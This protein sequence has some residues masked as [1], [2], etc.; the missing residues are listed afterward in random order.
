MKW[1]FKTIITTVC[2][3]FVG[4]TDEAC[5]AKELPVDD[6]RDTPSVLQVPRPNAIVTSASPSQV[7]AAIEKFWNTKEY[8]EPQKAKNLEDLTRKALSWQYR[9]GRKSQ[10][11]GT[12]TIGTNTFI[13]DQTF[14]LPGS[15]DFIQQLSRDIEGR[16]VA[17]ISETHSGYYGLIVCDKG[18]IIRHFMDEEGKISVNVGR[19]PD[20]NPTL[21]DDGVEDAWQKLV[22]ASKV[23]NLKLHIFSN[24]K[25]S[26]SKEL[27]HWESNSANLDALVKAGDGLA[28]SSNYEKA[29]ASY[30][31]A[32]ITAQGSMFERRGDLKSFELVSELVNKLEECEMQLAI[33]ASSDGAGLLQTPN[34]SALAMECSIADARKAVANSTHTSESVSSQKVSNLDEMA[35]ALSKYEKECRDTPSHS[36][37]FARAGSKTIIFDPQALLPSNGKLIRSLSS[38]SSG[39]VIAGMLKSRVCLLI[40][41]DQGQVTRCFVSVDGKVIANV[42]KLPEESPKFTADPAA[43]VQSA[44]AKL[45]PPAQLTDF[46]VSVFSQGPTTAYELLKSGKPDPV[47]K[48]SLVIASGGHPV[49]RA[50]TSSETLAVILDTADKD[51]QKGDYKAARMGYESALVHADMLQL[52]FPDHVKL[53]A[54]ISEIKTNISDC[55][56]RMKK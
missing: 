46:E 37:G 38:E 31:Q 26:L 13:Y 33:S 18:K 50:L 34:P 44:W 5:R 9:I 52:R 40:V 39:R 17:G 47:E 28:R 45:V 24:D 49:L 54:L 21:E 35:K 12:A 4:M 55:K 42:G 6:D 8:G 7:I 30:Q 43:G 20:E 19:L 2:L 1:T 23:T 15:V 3:L 41:C 25:E 22:P 32:L 48:D 56:A 27:E 29:K 36:L 53:A 16:V 14:I 51:A 10:V 11:V